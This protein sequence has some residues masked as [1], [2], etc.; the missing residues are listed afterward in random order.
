MKFQYK[1]PV[2]ETSLKYI[3]LM[4]DDLR[5]STWLYPSEGANS[6]AAA[7][8]TFKWITSFGFMELLVTD[9]GS[10]SVAS[11]IT[12]LTQEPRIKHH[13]T[14]PYCPWANGT[15][16]RLCGEVILVTRSLLS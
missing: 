8:A 6:D 4:K 7:S 3:L 2:D 14:T 9:E 11:L 12:S 10:H 16:E 1:G 15:I 13:S 5:S